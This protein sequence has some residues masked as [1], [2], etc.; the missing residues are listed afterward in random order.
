MGLCTRVQVLVT[1]DHLALQFQEVVSHL[2]WAL[3][4]KFGPSAKLVLLT[5][6]SLF[7]SSAYTLYAVRYYPE[8][9]RRCF[10]LVLA[11]H[12]SSGCAA[13]LDIVGPCIVTAWLS[14]R[15]LL[16]AASELSL[17]C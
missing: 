5:S 11:W 1:S 16:V 3:G 12:L 2:L 9:S 10:W 7:Q 17:R 15:K 4:T 13:V 14:G 6:Q 8:G